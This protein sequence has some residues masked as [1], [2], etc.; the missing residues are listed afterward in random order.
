MTG[1]G[2]RLQHPCHQQDRRPVLPCQPQLVVH[3]RFGAVGQA[4]SSPDAQIC[5]EAGCTK[6]GRAAEVCVTCSPRL[7]CSGC[8]PTTFTP[9][10]PVHVCSPTLL[11]CPTT[12]PFCCMS[13]L[14][15]HL[16]DA[17]SGLSDVC[18]CWIAAAGIHP[19]W[20]CINQT[21]THSSVCPG[22]H[23]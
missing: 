1:A 12:D 15:L 6:Q 10:P 8:L 2:S 21:L 20:D 18:E 9:Q 19:L 17:A 3:A 14:R 4:A 7:C 5:W 23:M 13:G 16:I 22:A 11:P